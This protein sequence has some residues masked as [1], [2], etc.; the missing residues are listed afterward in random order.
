MS[1]PALFLFQRAHFQQDLVDL[2]GKLNLVPM[3]IPSVKAACH[4]NSA[5]ECS[6]GQQDSDGIEGD[7]GDVTG[8]WYFDR[9]GSKPDPAALLG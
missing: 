8:R 5:L 4:H 7:P 2:A 1:V 3:P 9:F 6:V